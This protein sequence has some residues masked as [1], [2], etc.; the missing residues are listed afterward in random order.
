T[1]EQTFKRNSQTKHVHDRL[2]NQKDINK[3]GK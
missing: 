1:N 2:K 3:H